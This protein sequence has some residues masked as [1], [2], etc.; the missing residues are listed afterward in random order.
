MLSV[1]ATLLQI[2]LSMAAKDESAY[3]L[4]S[5]LSFS[6]GTVADQ[7]EWVDAKPF[8]RGTGFPPN[9]KS[10][11]YDRLP[12]AAVNTTRAAV[13]GLSRDT[14]GMYLSFASNT[15]DLIVNVTY[16]Y[17]SFE[18][19][20]FPRFYHTRL[21]LCG[22]HT[23]RPPSYICKCIC[24]ILSQFVPFLISTNSCLS[25]QHWGCWHGSLCF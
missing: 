5:D 18:M 16:V 1:A 3:A 10:A 15:T 2:V 9:K 6:T 23:S 4:G 25:S 13:W 21:Q 24:H 8:L 7:L 11:F 14:A 12:A 17:G 20:H 19:W 22:S